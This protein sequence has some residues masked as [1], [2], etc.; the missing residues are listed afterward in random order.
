MQGFISLI[1]TDSNIV[2]RKLFH[3]EAVLLLRVRD[4]GSQWLVWAS[5]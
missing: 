2:S 3:Q 5:A 1:G 4:S